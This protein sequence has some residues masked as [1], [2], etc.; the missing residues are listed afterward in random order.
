MNST[1]SSLNTKPFSRN[2]GRFI[3]KKNTPPIETK[4]T[5]SGPAQPTLKNFIKT[6][7]E[8]PFNPSGENGGLTISK[9]FGDFEKAQPTLLRK[10]VEPKKSIIKADNDPEGLVLKAELNMDNYVLKGQYE[11]LKKKFDLLTRR[12]EELKLK[13]RNL[14]REAQHQNRKNAELSE[15]NNALKERI[16]ELE[17]EN[18]E[19][20]NER[21]KSTP[22]SRP[23]LIEEETKMDD[24]EMRSLRLAMR[25]EAENLLMSRL[26][27]LAA[28]Q[29]LYDRSE[30]AHTNNL[31]NPEN[32][33][34]DNMTYEELL[35]LEERMGKVSRGL[36]IEQIKKIPKS[37]YHKKSHQH[38]E[39]C[40]ICFMEVESGAKM[41]KLPCC[42]EYHSKCI[43]QWLLNEKTCPICKKEVPVSE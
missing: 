25:Y 8:N 20:L 36:N 14:E 35:Q 11:D 41:R 10:E 5:F 15:E 39:T 31:D 6:K 23:M 33:N 3:I 30:P 24:N 7:G 22:S 34:P 29:V 13:N 2:T 21:Q 19:L 17:E 38:E 27:Q 9:G 4:K 43:K 32:I 1:N 37:V 16:E 26:S 40:S 18:Q 12:H 28:L 42:H